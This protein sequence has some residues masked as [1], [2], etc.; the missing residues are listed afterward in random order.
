MVANDINSVLRQLEAVEANVEKLQRI[1]GEIREL[2]PD[3]I[4]FGS[5]PVFDDR[6]R[7]FEDVLAALPTIDG[8]K[9]TATPID[10]NTLAQWRLD[11][12]EIGELTAELDADEAVEKP[13]REIAAYRHRLNKQR[14]R[15]IR[16]AM[17]DIIASVD[18][19]LDRLSA[20]DRADREVNEIVDGID[21][22]ALKEHIQAIDVLLGSSV[23]RPPRWSDLRRHLGFGM[24]QDMRDIVRMD[25]PE[26]KSGLSKVLYDDD[27]PLPVTVSDLSQLTPNPAG[28]VITR[29]KWS[30]I[31][32]EDFERLIFSLISSADKYENP[33]W[34]TKTKAPDRGRDLSVVRVSIDELSGV[35]R[36]KVIIQCK[37]WLAHS[38]GVD[39]IIKLKEQMRLWDPPVDVLVV[40]TSGRFSTDAVN[41]VEKHNQ[42]DSSLRIEMWPDSHLELLLASR[43]AL[44][45]EFRLR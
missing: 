41:Y 32:D 4:C 28:E 36:R 30:S 18:E 39:E 40:A 17:Q 7:T 14:R 45:A 23:S 21:W 35:T 37:H 26:V 16:Q 25:W 11:A 31:T 22:I 2:T 27:E 34:L 5:D 24:V 38:V 20:S 12:K 1:F 8:W 13:D 29:L 43:P 44:V 9:P 10:L 42:S 33:Q 3:G 15:L 19:T 6:V